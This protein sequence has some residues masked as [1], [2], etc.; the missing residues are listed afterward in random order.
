MCRL[1]ARVQAL[2]KD[3]WKRPGSVEG[4]SALDV[5]E[6][7]RAIASAMPG[8]GAEGEQDGAGRGGGGPRGQAGHS[9]ASRHRDGVPGERLRP[10]ARVC[11]WRAVLRLSAA[12]WDSC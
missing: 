8:G 10:L 11:T 12:R 5:A 3:L 9:G 7:A 2:L 1:G 4:L 6:A